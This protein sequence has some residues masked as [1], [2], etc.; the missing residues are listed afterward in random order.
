MIDSPELAGGKMTF[1]QEADC[2]NSG[3]QIIHFHVQDG[4]GG[5][6]ITFETEMWAISNAQE[7]KDLYD[8]VSAAFQMDDYQ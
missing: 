4:G 1:T 7:F 5:K 3:I 8:K 2:C 6:Y